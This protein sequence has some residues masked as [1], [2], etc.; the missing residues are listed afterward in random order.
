MKKIILLIAF[1]SFLLCSSCLDNPSDNKLN[2][3][4]Y[5][6]KA[7][8]DNSCK[9][10]S[11]DSGDGLGYLFANPNLD[12]SCAG[13]CYFN[14]PDSS[15]GNTNPPATGDEDSIADL[16]PYLD[17]VEAKNEA[18]NNSLST[19]N[20]NLNTQFEQ[21]NSNTTTLN[22]TLEKIDE[23]LQAIKD[24]NSSGG[25]NGSGDDGNN[26]DELD[27]IADGFTVNPDISS[28]LGVFKNQN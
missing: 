18:I 10:M 13:F 2:G 14:L 4:D 17:E 19:L 8:D 3:M 24:G 22:T 26:D 12:K 16:I 27:G 20:S 5:Q 6:G 11:N 25:D 9:T 23:T 15:G 7:S 1:K 28:E 21:I